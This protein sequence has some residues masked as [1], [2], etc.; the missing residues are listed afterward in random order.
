MIISILPWVVHYSTPIQ[1]TTQISNK[2]WLFLL[3]YLAGIFTKLNEVN[4]SI[5]YKMTTA[6]T[7][8]NKIQTPTKKNLIFDCVFFSIW[9]FNNYYCHNYKFLVLGLHKN[10]WEQ[11]G[12]AI[13]KFE[14]HWFRLYISINLHHQH[15]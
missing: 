10:F 1:F 14:N 2:I 4:L 5:Q 7:A 6:L 13:K 8:N 15:S 9:N 11:M 12:S 3:N